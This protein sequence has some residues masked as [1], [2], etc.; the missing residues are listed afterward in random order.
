MGWGWR[1]TGTL[2]GGEDFAMKGTA[3]HAK[4]VI[5]EGRR[6]AHTPGR[7]PG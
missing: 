2:T 6:P 4:T 7:A 5:A 1:V 3:C